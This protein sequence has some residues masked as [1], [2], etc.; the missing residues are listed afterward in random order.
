MALLHFIPI[1]TFKGY[2]LVRIEKTSLDAFSGIVFL[3]FNLKSQIK[4]SYQKGDF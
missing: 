1:Q 2:Y 4:K 3:D